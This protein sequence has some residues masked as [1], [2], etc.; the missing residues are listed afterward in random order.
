MLRPPKTSKDVQ[1]EV[2]EF[3]KSRKPGEK[4]INISTTIGSKGALFNLP[5]TQKYTITFSDEELNELNDKIDDL[6]S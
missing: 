4:E 5:L 1:N 3:I 6:H 2:I